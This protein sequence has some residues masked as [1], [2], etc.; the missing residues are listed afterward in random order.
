M[1][2][3]MLTLFNASFFTGKFVDFP[4]T[5]DL[6][7]RIKDSLFLLKKIQTK[8]LRKF[9]QKRLT[10]VVYWENSTVDRR[11]TSDE[12]TVSRESFV[13]L[14]FAR[15]LSTRQH[16]IHHSSSQGNG[17]LLPVYVY[18]IVYRAVLYVHHGCQEAKG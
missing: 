14:P 7:L 2:V 17:L 11:S 1:C 5:E 10:P 3:V 13:F 8:N 16:H 9:K 12:N 18:H 4:T 15:L 6:F